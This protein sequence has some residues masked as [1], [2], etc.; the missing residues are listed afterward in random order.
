MQPVRHTPFSL[1]DK[2]KKKIEDLVAMDIIEPVQG[3][4]PWVS[5][6][7]V[8]PKQ[9]DEI[10]LCM[11]MWRANEAIIRECYPIPTQ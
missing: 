7:V 2:E 6:V 9:S 1:C 5:P 4:A 8:V 10:C 3:P 11:D